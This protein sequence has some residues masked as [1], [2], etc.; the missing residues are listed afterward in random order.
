MQFIIQNRFLYKSA[1]MLSFDS[2]A[3]LFLSSF[4]A[5]FPVINPL[6]DGLIINGFLKGLDN[7]Q[8]KLAARKIAVNC[9]LICA[10]SIVLGHLILMV[11][12]LA[13]PVIQ[14]GGGLIICKTGYDLLMKDAPN[15]KPNA[16][17]VKGIDMDEVKMKLFYPLSF[18]IAID[19]GSISVIL[20]L[21]ATASV[22]G[23]F[24]K[25]SINYTMLAAAIVLIV[26]L[27]YLMI[28]HGPKLIKRLGESTNMIINKLVAFLMFSIGIQITLTGLAKIFHL[29]IL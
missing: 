9:I 25:T 12:G 11:F 6:G 17:E 19:P 24:L 18:P 5:L 2:L 20:T 21:M 16:T 10:C 1:S 23:S 14:V 26:F 3:Y 22:K 27:L 4:L 7:E 29:T 13:I 8:R 28:A 15:P